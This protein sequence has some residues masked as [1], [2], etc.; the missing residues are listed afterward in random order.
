[1]SSPSP[2]PSRFPSYPD[3]NTDTGVHRREVFFLSLAALES[4]TRD[5]SV[6]V[7]GSILTLRSSGQRYAVRE[8]MR[9]LGPAGRGMDIFGM[10]GKVLTLQELLS[11]G[12]TLSSNSMRIGAV[13]YDVQMGYLVQNLTG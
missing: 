5:R 7:D 3:D 12:A 1:M 13:E 11:S 4:K 2:T 10:T 8:A 6:M 9:V